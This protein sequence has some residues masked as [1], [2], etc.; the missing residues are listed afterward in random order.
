[1][2]SNRKQR[3]AAEAHWRIVEGKALDCKLVPEKCHV[4]QPT[5]SSEGYAVLS[6]TRSNG[7]HQF[8]VVLS[9]DDAVALVAA[10]LPKGEV[11]GPEPRLI[12]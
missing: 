8:C 5:N 3:F 1:M 11:V 9:A 2:I 6:F 7:K 10:L 4:K 12:A